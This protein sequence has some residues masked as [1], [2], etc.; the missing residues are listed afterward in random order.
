MWRR[1]G[2]TS[3][4]LVEASGVAL[5]AGDDIEA[6]RRADAPRSVRFVAGE[7]MRSRRLS[8]AHDSPRGR[9]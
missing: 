1:N 2:F 3:A 4:E 7:W 5:Y 6:F 8:V 9:S